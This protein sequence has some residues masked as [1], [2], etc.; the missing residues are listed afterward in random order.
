MRDQ[1]YGDGRDLV[2]W[3]ALV[4]LAD[5]LGIR[6]ILQVA[7]YRPSDPPGTLSTGSGPA[8]I[9]KAVL[10]HFRNLDRIQGLAKDAELE[11]EVLKDPWPDPELGRAGYIRSVVRRIAAPARRPMIV[12]LDPDTGIAPRRAGP[13]HVTQEEIRSIYEGLAAG[14]VLVFYQHAR[15]RRDWLQ[16]TRRLFAKAV[17]CRVQDVDTIT[18]P[19][20]VRDVAF[21]VIT[22]RQA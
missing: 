13:E 14:D 16:T 19:E 18:C 11:I 3:A 20:M 21:L 17:G 15:R 12:F 1:W 22:K 5:S 2:K 8:S 6:R 9:P 10:D 4:H 7:F